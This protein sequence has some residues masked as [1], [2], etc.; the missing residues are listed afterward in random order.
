LD[1]NHD[2]N[3]VAEEV[4][5]STRKRFPRIDNNGDGKINAAEWTIAARKESNPQS[6]QR[7]SG[8]PSAGKSP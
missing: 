6:N 5:E 8:K 2:G 3:L 1:K 4:D 7:E